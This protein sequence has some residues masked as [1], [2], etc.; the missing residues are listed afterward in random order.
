MAQSLFTRIRCRKDTQTAIVLLTTRVKK[1]DEDDWKKL[2]RLLGYL[3]Q[4]IKLL[5]ILRADRVNVLKWLLDASYEAHANM[6]G[7]TGGNMSM[8]KDVCG[9]IISISKKQKINTKSLTEAELIGSDDAMSHMLWTRHFLEAHGYEINKNILYQDNMSPMLLENN[10][11]KSS[12]KKTRKII[13]CATIL[14]R[15]G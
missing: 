13:T 1:L 12:T 10:G 15:I 4:T 3:K 2:R 7:H 6:R 5:L 14:Y 8:G 9:S 11:N